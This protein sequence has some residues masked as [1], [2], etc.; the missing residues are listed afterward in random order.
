MNPFSFHAEYVP[1]LAKL[2]QVN[3]VHIETA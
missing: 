1:Y 3:N 2:N